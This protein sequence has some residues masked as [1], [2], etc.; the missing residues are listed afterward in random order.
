MNKHKN[1]FPKSEDTY[2]D[3]NFSANDANVSCCVTKSIAAL[4]NIHN[5]LFINEPTTIIT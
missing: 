2:F 3:I 4:H 1:Y 5:M